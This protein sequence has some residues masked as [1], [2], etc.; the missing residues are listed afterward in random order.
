MLFG[1]LGGAKVAPNSMKMNP[2][3]LKTAM[4]PSLHEYYRTLRDPIW[5]LLLKMVQNGYPKAILVHSPSSGRAQ[6]TPNVVN[7]SLVASWKT[8]PKPCGFVPHSAVIPQNSIYPGL[9]TDIYERCNRT[10]H[11]LHTTK[12]ERALRALNGTLLLVSVSA[13]GPETMKNGLANGRKKS[14]Y[15]IIFQISVKASLR[16][17]LFCSMHSVPCMLFNMLLY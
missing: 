5:V 2:L 14:R 4:K 15:W 17:M 3:W 8:T 16:G 12:R 1:S 7:V 11:T 6:I 10:T 9:I 13:E